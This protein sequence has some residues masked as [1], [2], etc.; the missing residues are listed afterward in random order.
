MSKPNLSRFQ[1]P[2][3]K[4]KALPRVASSVLLRA[5]C[6]RANLP[7]EVKSMSLC[8]RF[9]Y[10]TATKRKELIFPYFT[11]CG[12]E[13]SQILPSLPPAKWQ[14]STKRDDAN[15]LDARMGDSVRQEVI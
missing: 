13:R 5:A 7:T 12:N 4:K 11:D 10:R 8:Q 2:L 15:M 3:S 1:L 6:D 14:L 9:F